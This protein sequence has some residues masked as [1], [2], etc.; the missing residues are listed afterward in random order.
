M[1]KRRRSPVGRRVTKPSSDRDDEPSLRRTPKRSQFIRICQ[2]CGVP[3]F[4]SVG[5]PDC[6][7]HHLGCMWDRKHSHDRKDTEAQRDQAQ[8][9]SA[10]LRRHERGLMKKSEAPVTPPEEK[11]ALLEEPVPP[12]TQ[13]LIP[14]LTGQP[15]S[16]HLMP[17]YDLR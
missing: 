6:E 1:A 12:P 17:S 10:Y 4:V 14:G 16:E 8:A 7:G 15:N 11:P 9:K 3:I 2:W 13:I 5:D